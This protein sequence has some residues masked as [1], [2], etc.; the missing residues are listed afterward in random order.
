MGNPWVEGYER[1]WQT[2]QFK[3]RFTLGK[4]SRDKLKTD[5]AT[6]YGVSVEDIH[7][8]DGEIAESVKRGKGYKKF[9]ESGALKTMLDGL[10]DR[11]Y[12]G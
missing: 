12:I 2:L 7:I 3:L 6:K 8:S 9:A 11:P 10:K 1:D 5:F 4:D